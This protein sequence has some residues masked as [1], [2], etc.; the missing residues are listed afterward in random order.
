MYNLPT[1][2]DWNLVRE[3]EKEVEER[4]AALSLLV[5][6]DSGQVEFLERNSGFTLFLFVSNKTNSK[7][8]TGNYQTQKRF[9]DLS[10]GSLSKCIH[11]LQASN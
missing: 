9:A 2:P 8:L 11:L 10:F 7:K 6:S 5:L 1:I 4:K 3:T